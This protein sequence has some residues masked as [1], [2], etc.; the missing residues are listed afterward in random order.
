LLEN[1]LFSLEKALPAA[2]TVGRSYVKEREL[3]LS[4]NGVIRLAEKAKPYFSSPKAGP[5]SHNVVSRA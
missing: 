1:A 5:L 4:N 2:H 3:R